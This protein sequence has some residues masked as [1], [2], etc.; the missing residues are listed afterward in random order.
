MNKHNISEYAIYDMTEIETSKIL[1]KYLDMITDLN[2]KYI[3]EADD[4]SKLIFHL[5][6]ELQE[7]NHAKLDSLELRVCSL[8]K[9]T[10]KT[11][12]CCVIC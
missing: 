9:N 3:G 4:I 7:Q 11:S 12:S 2:D 8:E 10:K 5:I 1:N 6:L